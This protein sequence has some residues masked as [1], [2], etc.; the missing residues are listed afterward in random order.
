MKE[1]PARLVMT[2][3]VVGGSVYLSLSRI[4]IPKG[5]LDPLGWEE[6]IQLKVFF[7]EEK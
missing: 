1:Y 6:N 7:D 2:K 3:A 5:A 4:E